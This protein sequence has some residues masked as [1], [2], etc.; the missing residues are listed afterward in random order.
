MSATKRPGVLARKVSYALAAVLGAAVWTAL[1]VW[2]GWSVAPF[3]SPKTQDVL[4]A[5]NLSV[6][7]GVV[8]NLIYLAYD[9]I[10]FKAAGDLVTAATGLVTAVVLWRV[11]PFDFSAYSFDWTLV[12][13][14]IVMI[15][16]VGSILA[17]LVQLMTLVRLAVIGRAT[18]H[19][20]GHA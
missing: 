19:H 9:P 13:R 4:W 3:L 18:P 5:V 2:P 7:A 20:R 17:M 16:L 10:W 6:I 14:V 12:A 11:F 8:A 1:N 15:A